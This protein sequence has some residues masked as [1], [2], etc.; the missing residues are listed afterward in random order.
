M[1]KQE[2]ATIVEVLVTLKKGLSTMDESTRR[3]NKR[4]EEVEIAP[5]E[6]NRCAY[7]K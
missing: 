1:A 3:C 6:E 5:I 2:L 7:R 4:F